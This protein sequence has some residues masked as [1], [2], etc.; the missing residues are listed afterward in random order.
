MKTLV[1]ILAGAITL[2]GADASPDVRQVMSAMES[3]KKAML[4]RD[5]A[6]LG[7]L[8]SDDLMYTHSAGKV[9]SKADFVESIAS[10][11]SIVEK[12]EYTDPVIRVYGN[13]AIWRGRVDL[14]HSATNIVHM[15]VLH[16]WVRTP[17]GWKMVARQATKL[18][19]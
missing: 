11:K 2:L 9:E 4:T 16:V 17:G 6:A 18:A 5:G 15:D 1:L 13:T 8:L 7:K 19:K 14:W 12:L 10:G 3:M